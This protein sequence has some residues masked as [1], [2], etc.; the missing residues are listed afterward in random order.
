MPG[1]VRRSLAADTI[2]LHGACRGFRFL[3]HPEPPP[4]LLLL[5]SFGK[6]GRKHGSTSRIGMQLRTMPMHGTC[7]PCME[8]ITYYQPKIQQPGQYRLLDL[9]CLSPSSPF[10][11]LFAPRLSNRQHHIVVQ[12][13]ASVKGTMN[14]KAARLRSLVVFCIGTSSSRMSRFFQNTPSL[15]FTTSE[16]TGQRR[17]HLES[18]QDRQ[19]APAVRSLLHQVPTAG[20]WRRAKGR[21]VKGAPFS[22]PSSNPP[23]IRFLV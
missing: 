18:A 13:N 21:Q 2:L 16:P 10:S 20:A 22:V 19:P 14:R 9:D 1:C 12:K 23:T 5:R 17:R 7:L 8:Y 15:H 3:L 11:F 6:P 4:Q